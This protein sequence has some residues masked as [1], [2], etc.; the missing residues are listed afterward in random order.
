MYM[1]VCAC[2]LYIYILCES[3]ILQELFL[4]VWFQLYEKLLVISKQYGLSSYTLSCNCPSVLYI[5]RIHNS[6]FSFSVSVCLYLSLPLSVSICL[7]IRLI[8]SLFCRLIFAVFVSVRLSASGCLYLPL[9]FCL[10]LC[11]YLC[12]FTCYL[13]Y[14]IVQCS[15]NRR[16]VHSSRAAL[17][18]LCRACYNVQWYTKCAAI[19]L[20]NAA[21]K[22]CLCSDY[23]W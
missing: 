2:I 10:S 8:S 13:C 3:L 7:F 21:T 20:K 19:N 23:E 17:I 5:L 18:R 9:Y 22:G 15:T 1:I 16:F 12:L 6:T 11:L 4:P 14:M